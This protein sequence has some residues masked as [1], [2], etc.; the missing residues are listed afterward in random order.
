M[1]QPYIL[2][3]HGFISSPKSIKATQT[4]A[5]LE[6]RGE[7]ERFVCPELPYSPARAQALIEQTITGFKGH[8]FMLI[9]SSLG[10]FYS[11]W[12]AETF[13]AR[14]VL[15]NP[16]VRPWTHP[17]LLGPQ[18]NMYTGEQFVLTQAHLDELLPMVPPVLTPSRYWLL[19]ETG[20]E[21]L[22]Y[23]HAVEHYAGSRQTVIEG[24]NHSFQQWVPML[25]G[26]IAWADS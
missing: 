22:D 9:G 17:Q 10:G 26:V 5:F 21:T 15:V 3:L 18:T 25:G 1:T 2:Y 6:A 20:D 4:K 12:A 11:T 8:P 13:D 7:G 16:A 14:A 19:V 23:R 24:G